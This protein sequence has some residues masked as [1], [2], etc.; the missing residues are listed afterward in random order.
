MRIANDLKLNVL[1][2]GL[3]WAG[4]YGGLIVLAM[5]IFLGVGRYFLGVVQCF[6]RVGQ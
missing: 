1:L 4:V 5:F 2:A 6:L 3:G